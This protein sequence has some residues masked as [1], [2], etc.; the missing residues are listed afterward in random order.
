[1]TPYEIWRGNKP[2]LKHFHEF[3]SMC[4]M[5]NDREH[6]SKFDSKSDEG[7]F[8]R[9]SLDRKAYKVFNKR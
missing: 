2:N 7:M 4:F 1:M 9:Y 5:L 6:W 8:L 3:R